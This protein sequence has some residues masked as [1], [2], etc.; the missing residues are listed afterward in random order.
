MVSPLLYLCNISH[1]LG[2][3]VLHIAALLGTRQRIRYLLEHAP[4]TQIDLNQS[5]IYFAI[6][7]DMKAK[8][9]ERITAFT[10][11]QY[12]VFFNLPKALQWVD[13][14]VSVHKVTTPDDPNLDDIRAALYVGDTIQIQYIR[15]VLDMLFV[16]YIPVLATIIRA[17]CNL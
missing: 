12:P 13:T 10:L 14:L 2:R 7:G 9:M 5:V 11:S 6:E 16:M 17:Y 1:F 8:R 4:P 15:D 3:S